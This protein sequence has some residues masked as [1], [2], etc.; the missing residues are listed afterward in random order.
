MTCYSPVEF[1]I[2]TNK[3]IIS[4]WDLNFSTTCSRITHKQPAN[5]SHFKNAGNIKLLS[6]YSVAYKHRKQD[7]SQFVFNQDVK[8][9]D[10]R[11]RK[12]TLKQ[13]QHSRI[14][15]FKRPLRIR[16]IRSEFHSYTHTA[17]QA[18]GRRA[19]PRG[20]PEIPHISVSAFLGHHLRDSG[21]RAQGDMF[22]RLSYPIIQG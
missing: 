6:L 11:E 18:G 21:T 9:P 22:S 12:R 1:L 4:T 5:I 15:R 17:L 7:F 2:V 13:S 16:T 14:C 19:P 10:Q 3:K 20:V 8:L